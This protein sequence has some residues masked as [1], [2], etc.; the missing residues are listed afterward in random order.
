VST[1]SIIELGGF[2]AWHEGDERRLILTGHGLVEIVDVCLMME[3]VVE[4][5][6]RSID[7]RLERILRGQILLWQSLKAPSDV[8]ACVGVEAGAHVRIWQRG[9]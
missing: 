7:V 8:W 2:G 6:R 4:F 5:H 1:T 9:D 3:I